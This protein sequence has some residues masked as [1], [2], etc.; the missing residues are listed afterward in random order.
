MRI[1]P[2]VEGDGEERAFPELLRRLRDESGVFDLV[3]NRPIRRRRW[4]FVTES[5]LRKIVRLAALQECQGILVLFDSDKDCPRELAAEVQAW[6]HS[7]ARGIPCEV[8]IAH[9]E[10]E[11]WFLASLESLRGRS[12]IRAD[13]VSPP[14]PES[15]RGA[16]EKLNAYMASYLP[17]HDQAALSAVFDLSSAY[18]ACRSFR[19]LVNAFGIVASQAGATL[20]EWP[21]PSWLTR[22]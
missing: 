19:R 5:S 16:K 10:Y 20:Q 12:G 15:I 8:V 17:V 9:C 3:F 7:E 1:Q 11:A 4:E 6:A 13:A 21:P 22:E 2:V 14:D 18:R